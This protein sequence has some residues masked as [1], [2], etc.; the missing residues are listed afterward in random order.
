MSDYYRGIDFVGDGL[1]RM[2]ENREQDFG[3]AGGGVSLVHLFGAIYPAV[4]NLIAES[5]SGVAVE[6]RVI[7]V[8]R[9]RGRRRGNRRSFV[10]RLQRKGQAQ[11]REHNYGYR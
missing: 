8:R 10:L 4:G 5:E 7:G 2:F 9:R 11:A 1:G 3:L 6:L